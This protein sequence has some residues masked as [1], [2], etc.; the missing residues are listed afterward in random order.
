MN[1]LSIIITIWLTMWLLT[2]IMTKDDIQEK[3]EDVSWMLG[4][5][6]LITTYLIITLL[7]APYL[8]FTRIY[9]RIVFYIKLRAIKKVFKKIKKKYGITDELIEKHKSQKPGNPNVK[10]TEKY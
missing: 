6:F 10:K 7:L 2:I 8:F 1:T 4:I 9:E 3:I 5:D